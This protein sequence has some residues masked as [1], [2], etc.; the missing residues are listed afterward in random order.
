M[1]TGEDELFDRLLS[2]ENVEFLF[3]MAKAKININPALFAQCE[4]IL[5]IL[6]VKCGK[7]Y[8]A[9]PAS[10]DLIGSINKAAY[11]K[12]EA[13]LM[14]NITGSGHQ[15]HAPSKRSND[16][17][18]RAHV[19]EISLN[20]SS[21]SQSPEHMDTFGRIEPHQNAT[22]Q[23]IDN[24]RTNVRPSEKVISATF[25]DGRMSMRPSEK[26]VSTTFD[27]DDDI[28]TEDEKNKLIAEQYISINNLVSAANST[29]ITGKILTYL[30]HPSIMDEFIKMIE[31]IN[32]ISI[33]PKLE[34]EIIT[35]EEFQHIMIEF[36]GLKPQINISPKTVHKPIETTI[37]PKQPGDT[38]GKLAAGI[39]LPRDTGRTISSEGIESLRDTG[40][41]ISSPAEGIESLRD[42]VRTTSSEGIELPRD[43]LIS[44]SEDV[45]DIDLI[46]SSEISVP[47]NTFESPQNSTGSLSSSEVNQPLNITCPVDLANIKSSDLHLIKK[48]LTALD[49]LSKNSAPEIKIKID[50]EKKRI[51]SAVSKYSEHLSQQQ[52]DLEIKT[53]EA[54]S[55]GIN[56]IERSKDILT[57]AIVPKFPDVLRKFIIDLDKKTK[58]HEIALKSHNIQ[59]NKN[60][61]NRFNHKFS[62]IHQSK[63]ITHDI[64][65]GLYDITKLFDVL[66]EKFSFL[67]FATNDQNIVTVKSD[68]KFDLF[69]K[70]DD[71]IFEILGFVG[72]ASSYQNKTLY[73]GS[74]PFN[75]TANEHLVLRLEGTPSNECQLTFGSEENVHHCV[76]KSSGG[77]EL[78]HIHLKFVDALDKTYDI[79]TEFKIS[80]L[81]KDTDV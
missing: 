73:T 34:E 27:D 18:K 31:Q 39:E 56:A 63:I 30:S 47:K 1:D 75:L 36:Y 13:H 38:E 35:R 21:G 7:P 42:T 64:P 14:K 17:D 65:Y 45:F 66:H 59:L 20:I 69:I 54:K 61:I 4:K 77:V 58:I 2:V 26:V 8:A 37:Q 80:L 16:W 41:T 79:D 6:L 78:K 23:P 76:K 52:K 68:A 62:C 32:K 81:I 19:E 22:H 57:L 55:E 25:D 49:S 29:D 24:S 12:F 48:H 15:D 67:Q 46:V 70:D 33:K 5:K 28:V 71:T 43:P 51:K 53:T 72:R 9:E 60:N 3:N 50:L 10:D 11:M 40:R 44:N 74:R